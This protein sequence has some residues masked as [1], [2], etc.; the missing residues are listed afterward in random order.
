M[1][2]EK[3]HFFALHLHHMKILSSYEINHNFNKSSHGIRH[4]FISYPGNHSDIYHLD[5]L[6]TTHSP[7]SRAIARVEHDFDTC[8]KPPYI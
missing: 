2:D 5:Q 6:I 1:L 3:V 7:Y 4:V 8:D